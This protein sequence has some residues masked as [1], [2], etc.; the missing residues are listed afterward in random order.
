MSQQ[1]TALVTAA[2]IS[3]LAGVT[4]ATVSN[5]RRRHTDFPAPVGGT[6]SRPL[7]DLHSVEAWLTGRDQRPETTPGDELRAALRR[8]AQSETSPAGLLSAVVLAVERLG[9][10]GRKQ[11]LRVSE[12]KFTHRVS[13]VVLEHAAEALTAL[14]SSSSESDGF[15]A[16][17]DDLLRTLIRCVDEEGP[18]AA[19]EVLTPQGEHH[20][21]VRGSYFTPP[22]LVEMMAGLLEEAD[23]RFP[24]SVFDPACGSGGFLLAAAEHGAAKL[25]GQDLLAAQAAYTA[26]R[27]ALSTPEASVRVRAGDSLRSDAFSSLTVA[28][29]LCNP[30]YADRDWGHDVL[31]YDSRW[32]YGLPPSG[33]SELAWVQHCLAHLEPAGHA[34]LVLPPGTAERSSGRRIR[35]ELVRRGALRAVAELPPGMSPP[36]HIG[37]HVWVLQRPEAEPDVPQVLFVT[38]SSERTRQEE[39]TIRRRSRNRSSEFTDVAEAVVRYWREFHTDPANFRGDPGVARA[40][41]VVDILGDTVDLTPSRHVRVAEVVDPKATDGQAREVHTGLA[42]ALERLMTATSDITKWSVT[43]GEPAQWRSATVADL[44]RGGALTVHRTRPVGKGTR[45][46]SVQPV[47]PDSQDT[48]PVL[49]SSDVARQGLASGS[50]GEQNLGSPAPIEVGDVIITELSEYAVGNARVADQR[51]AGSLLGPYLHLLRPDSERLDPYFLACFLSSEDNIN[52]VTT[53]SSLRRVNVSRLRV[54]LLPLERQQEYGTMFKHL[55][56]L[57]NAADQAHERA[58]E[59]LRTLSTGLTSGALLPPEDGGEGE[60]NK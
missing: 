59:V 16:E 46:E 58:K 45:A 51:D 10:Q 24:R 44:A 8:H 1:A 54:P 36:L 56:E 41:R 60:T 21:G 2:D 26:A 3:R 29:V 33:E 32:E 42:L 52:R 55:L 17:Y 9:R 57:R 53:G 38:P 27:T 23:G 34:V 15:S 43:E 40:V 4:R 48:T 22:V 6:G 7:Y 25:Y 11:L 20:E 12:E 47:L 30:P 35:A 5:W 28:A 39:R 49:T 50:R 18:E 13:E 31:A 19:F 37:L 14:D